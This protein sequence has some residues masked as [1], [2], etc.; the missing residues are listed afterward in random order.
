MQNEDSGGASRRARFDAEIRAISRHLERHGVPRLDADDVKEEPGGAGQGESNPERAASPSRRNRA[1]ELEIMTRAELIE[2]LRSRREEAADRFLSMRS[3]VAAARRTLDKVAVQLLDEQMEALN[4]HGHEEPV[5]PGDAQQQRRRRERSR[6]RDYHKLQFAADHGGVARPSRGWSG[7]TTQLVQNGGEACVV[8]NLA[9]GS[10][11][12][13]HHPECKML[14]D[15]H[16]PGTYKENVYTVSLKWALRTRKEFVNQH[17]CCYKR[18]HEPV[19]GAMGA[20]AYQ[21]LRE[22]LAHD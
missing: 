6:A 22:E 13:V 21:E 3:E 12:S 9:K 2:L 11:G 19:W 5:E 18:R 14:N 4:I 8:M 1:D 7:R 10:L 17:G 15:K 16:K 20:A